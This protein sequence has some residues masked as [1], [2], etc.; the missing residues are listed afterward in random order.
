M[1]RLKRISALLLSLIMLCL[2]FCI[3]A[4]AASKKNYDKYKVY[5]CIG[6]SVASGY[7]ALSNNENC[8]YMRLKG[9]YSDLVAKK[10]NAKLNPLAVNG[11]RTVEVRYILDDTYKGDKY[12]GKYIN[13]VQTLDE[14]DIAQYRAKVKEA[15]VISIGLCSNDIFTIPTDVMKDRVADY[16]DKWDD[17]WSTEIGELLKKNNVIGAMERLFYYA[18][19][20]GVLS[21]AVP[22]FLKNMVVGINQFKENFNVITDKIYEMNPDVTIMVM[23]VCSPMGKMPLYKGGKE[24]GSIINGG[25][26]LIN[27]YLRSG[28]KNADKYT[29][30]DAVDIDSPYQDFDSLI[31]YWIASPENYPDV[32]HPN[33][34]GHKYI[35]DQLM[36][37]LPETQFIDIKDAKNY[38]AIVKV[39]NAGIM[40]GDGALHFNPTETVTEKQLAYALYRL[41]GHKKSASYQTVK[42]WCT[43]KKIFNPGKDASATVT[44]AQVAKALKAYAKYAGVK[45]PYS[46]TSKSTLTRDDLAGILVKYIK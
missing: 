6:D 30:V 23:S 9:A 27:E 21:Y 29:Y 44:K 34:S 38:D 3:P 40:I 10:L 17:A 18:G 11:E 15:D 20:V 2:L 39:Y 32:N 28:C 22:E 16:T 45:N 35:A 8:S 12:L 1:K 37:V 25:T 24:V 41:A 19:E 43:D 42:K 7:G 26:D 13:G 33:A 31:D 14:K 46:S 5:T 4:G 36:A